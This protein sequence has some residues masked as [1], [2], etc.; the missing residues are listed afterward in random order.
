MARTPCSARVV[1]ELDGLKTKDERLGAF[2]GDL[3]RLASGCGHLD[4]GA[5]DLLDI[6]NLHLGA[7]PAVRFRADGELV[8]FNSRDDH[9]DLVR[10]EQRRLV[11]LVSRARLSLFHVIAARSA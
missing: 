9:I 8:A 5:D 6:G 2:V 3:S 10:L 1:E 11:S 4:L 7:C